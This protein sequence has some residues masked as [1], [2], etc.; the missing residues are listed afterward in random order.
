MSRK[1]SRRRKAACSSHRSLAYLQFCAQHERLHPDLVATVATVRPV[2][3]IKFLCVR[4]EFW[5]AQ[6]VFQQVNGAWSCASADPRLRWMTG[7]PMA[8][9]HLE[10]LRLGASYDWG[11]GPLQS[12]HDDLQ[13]G[14]P[15]VNP[16]PLG[17]AIPLPQA[18]G[19]AEYQPGS[20]TGG[21]A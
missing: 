9:I 2:K 5:T 12:H 10:L 14:K 21:P 13:N 7:K 20:R 11:T 6:A 19:P 4:T 15:G 3:A 16:T 1:T 17:T 8:M 18:D